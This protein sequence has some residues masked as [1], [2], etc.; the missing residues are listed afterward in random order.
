MN[1]TNSLLPPDHQWLTPPDVMTGEF[2]G[3]LPNGDINVFYKETGPRGGWGRIRQDD[4]IPGELKNLKQGCK[5]E[6]FC[7]DATGPEGKKFTIRA[8]KAPWY[9]QQKPITMSTKRQTIYYVI[10]LR[11]GQC[12]NGF[13]YPPKIHTQQNEDGSYCQPQVDEIPVSEGCYAMLGTER[14]YKF[15]NRE[16]AQHIASNIPGA[17]VEPWE[18]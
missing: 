15:D 11:T 9:F 13:H 5:I 1:D 12:V 14:P 8:R 2:C 6:R 16:G 17:R 4:F 10:W 18:D 7:G 3:L